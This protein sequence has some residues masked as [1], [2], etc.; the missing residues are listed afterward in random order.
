MGE[1]VGGRVNFEWF[2]KLNI[3]ITVF[4]WIGSRLGG[5]GGGGGGLVAG[6]VHLGIVLYS[7]II[8]LRVWPD[9]SG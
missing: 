8:Q 9:M 1:H 7:Q 3:T 6:L 2:V 5:W 4:V